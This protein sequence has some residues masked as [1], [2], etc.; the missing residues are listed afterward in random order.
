MQY[1]RQS[2]TTKLAAGILLLTTPI[3]VLAL[4]I[5]F[6]Q[7][8]NDIRQEAKERA[9]SVL[10]TTSL[11]VKQ[12][13]N[14][15]ETA[16]NAN[17]WLITEHL[18]PDSL[19]SLSRRIVMLNANVNGCSITTEPYTFPQY[20]RYF[21]A[22]SVRTGSDSITTVREAEYE[23][24][25]KVWYKKPHSQGTACWVD[26][27]DDYNEGTLSASEMIASYC[28]PIYDKDGRFV[29][30]ISTDLSLSMLA[31]AIDG[32]K[33]YPN[34]YF[35]MLGEDGRYYVHPDTTRLISKTIFDITDA[36]S[37][38]DIIALGHEMTTGQKGT[39]HI[40]IGGAPCHV[41]YQ[42]VPGTRWS[43][44]LVCPESDIMKSYY[45]LTYIIV[46]LLIVGILLILLLCR[47]IVVNAVS[48]L[49]RLVSQA[50]LL[51]AGQYDEQIPHTTRPDAVGRLQNSFA[52]MQE[53]LSRHVSDI[54]RVNDETQ[55]RNAELQQ[56]RQLAEKAGKQKTA[57]IQ[58]MTHQIRTPLN[59]ISGF[60]QVLRDDIDEL[61]D[62]ECQR[63]TD[64]MER[65]TK[66]LDR[67]VLM[68]YDSSESGQSEELLSHRQQQVFCNEIAR[69][70]I[71][72]TH[73]HFPRLPIK[74]ETSLPDTFYIRSNALYL[75]RSMREI[76][77]NSA[78]YSDKEQI[79]LQ[80]SATAD[81]VRFVF[82]DTG[83]G[84]D[85]ADHQQLYQPFYKVSDLSEGLG[86]GLPLT[87]RH[88]QNLGGTLTLDTDYHEGC[89]FI[90]ELP[91]HQDA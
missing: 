69:E 62:S 70:S 68:L 58:N 16:T 77:Y 72:S 87:K 18:Q 1:I 85:E 27:F 6:L 60:A 20:G 40:N 37:R 83:P 79:T 7:S 55:Q 90:M 45:H 33:P 84:I 13:L 35:M 75:M 38:P 51:T 4:G 73:Q 2:L 24:F 5:L 88:V 76:L 61:P 31:K 59:I 30:V 52:T 3:F 19:L 64:I 63:I 41:C 50:Q 28:K 8:R 43:I 12:Y 21:S 47:R 81:V 17:D 89:R 23:Y 56:A 10:Y 15:V 32:D 14:T 29:A 26:P 80:V 71:A 74:F 25:D 66:T 82:S 65:N 11:H 44:A 36:Q 53:S 49:N 46:P 9:T 54:H 78:K 39:M 86:L 48:P 91:I 34:A 22:Y 57:F 67:M 42:P